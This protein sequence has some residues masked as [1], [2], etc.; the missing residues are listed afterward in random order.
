M[1]SNPIIGTSGKP[2]YEGKSLPNTVQ[3]VAQTS[4]KRRTKTKFIRQVF[5]KSLLARAR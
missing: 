2:F 5:A 3:A 1:G 4:A